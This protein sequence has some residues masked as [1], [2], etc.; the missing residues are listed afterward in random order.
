VASKKIH[1]LNGNHELPFSLIALSCHESLLKTAWGINVKLHINL[2]ESLSPITSK[3]SPS[4]T[5]PLFVDWESSETI[6]YSLIANKVTG[7]FLVKEL[8]N[9]DFILELSG[10]IKNSELQEIIKA[11]KEIKGIAIAT[12]INPAKIK[13]NC[14]FN[15]L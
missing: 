9:I 1:K 3:D 6:S 11:L 8:P 5:F 14:A 15:P 2:K 10:S 12:E 4:N 7:N 13:R